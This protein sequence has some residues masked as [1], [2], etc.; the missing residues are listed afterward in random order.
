VSLASLTKHL[1][2]R[3]GKEKRLNKQQEQQKNTRDPLT[4]PN[5]LE[6]IWGL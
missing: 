4:S 1:R 2:I 3:M 5:A 6:L